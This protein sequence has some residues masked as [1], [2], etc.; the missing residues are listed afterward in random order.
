MRNG[1]VADRVAILTQ[2]SDHVATLT[3]SKPCHPWDMR[4][5]RE[6]DQKTKE[7]NKKF[8]QTREEVSAR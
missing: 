1:R 5:R 7:T 4:T 8:F 6:K 2:R 3:L